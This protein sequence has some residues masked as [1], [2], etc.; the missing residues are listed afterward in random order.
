MKSVEGQAI[1]RKTQLHKNSIK[2]GFFVRIPK[3]G[4]PFL[5]LLYIKSYCKKQKN[6]TFVR[7][8]DYSLNI[9]LW[10]HGFLISIHWDG[11][12]SICLT[13]SVPKR[14]LDLALRP[15][16]RCLC[17]CY[18]SWGWCQ[19]D[20]IEQFFANW[21]SFGGSL[22]IFWKDKVAQRNGNILGNFLL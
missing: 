5:Y 14:H 20:Q 22:M 6:T 19:G 17:P 8:S 15:N 12:A 16:G 7:F 13:F 4:M 21:A 9:P 2:C 18:Q 1:N 10:G 11:Y 3:W